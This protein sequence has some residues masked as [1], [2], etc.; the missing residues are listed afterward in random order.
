LSKTQDAKRHRS[1]LLIN[2]ERNMSDLQIIGLP[3][4]N[5]VWATRIACAEKGI[6]HENVAADPHTSEID[7]I[8]PLG[9]IPVMRHGDFVL[10]ESLAICRYIDAAFDGP[11]L[12][13]T[14][15]REAALAEQWTS[16]I[17]TSI[18]PVLIRQ[19]LFAYMF[20]K[21][22]DGSPDRAKI[23]AVLPQVENCLDAV[24]KAIDAKQLGA[25]NFRIADAYLIPILFY[26]Q[27]TPEA[28]GIITKSPALADYLDRQTM[29]KSVRATMPPLNSGS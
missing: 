28:G 10:A 19:Y 11:A 1:G 20:P 12:T 2:K 15:P 13:P 4:S 22:P 6:A 18:E 9:K 29:R 25:R 14:A 7:A 16:I 21:T 23:E 24:S 8:H 5:Y 17:L 27:R 3:Q 26:L